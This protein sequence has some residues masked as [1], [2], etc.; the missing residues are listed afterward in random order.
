M[1]VPSGN[2]ATL[3][4]DAGAFAGKPIAVEE[5]QLRWGTI[6]LRNADEVTLRG[7]SIST[8]NRSSGAFIAPIL[9]PFAMTA[10]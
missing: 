10:R 5:R 3:V 1:A 9:P 7:N 2:A 8:I 4:Q 6:H